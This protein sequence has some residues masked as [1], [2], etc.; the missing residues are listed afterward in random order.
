MVVWF[1]GKFAKPLISDKLFIYPGL[2]K[3]VNINIPLDIWKVEL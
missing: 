3:I 1:L 2:L